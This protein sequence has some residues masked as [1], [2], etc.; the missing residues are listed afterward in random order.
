MYHLQKNFKTGKLEEYRTTQ[1][2]R[3]VQNEKYISDFDELIGQIKNL[4]CN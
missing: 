4:N 1:K 3:A 2:I